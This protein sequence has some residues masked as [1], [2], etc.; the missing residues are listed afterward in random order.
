MPLVSVNNIKL[1]YDHQGHGEDLIL[2]GGMT[3]NHLG[4]N[5]VM[6]F[7]IKDYKVLRPDN[8]GAGQSEAPSE[9]YT[10]AEMAEDIIALMDLL[11]IQKASIIGHSMGGMMLQYLLLHHPQRICKA[12]I[13]SSSSKVPETSIFSI[14]TRMK[15]MQAKLD[16]ELMIELSFPWLF[17]SEFM[18]DKKRVQDTI[19][20]M[21]NNPYPQ[22]PVG[23]EGQGRAVAHFDYRGKLKNVSTETLVLVGKEDL[24]TP[25]CCSEY[26]HQQMPSSSFKVIEKVAH[27][28]QIES[29]AKTAEIILDFLKK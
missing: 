19:N 4:W 17:S 26:I 1:F 8:R 16:K 3:S 2:L 7:L 10:I 14:Q 9:H 23:Y 22:T 18:S 24:M 13:S 20:V 27:I 11:Q 6:P 15:L 5:A 25:V 21:M 29:P 28:P 12:V